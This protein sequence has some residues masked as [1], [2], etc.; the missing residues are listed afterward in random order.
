MRRT[1]R[2]LSVAALAGAVVGS[3]ASA[4]S[5][6]PAAEVS[7]GTVPPGG[8]V[9]VSVSCDSLGGSAPAALEATSEAFEEGTVQLKKVSGKDEKQAGAAYSG[10]ARVPPAENVEGDPDAA[11]PASA[12]TVDGTCPA[13]AGGEGKPWSATFTVAQDSGGG[14]GAAEGGAADGGAADGGGS[15]TEGGMGDGE[16]DGGGAEGGKG[17]VDG[18][19]KGGVDGGQGSSE[20][21]SRPCG[22]Q[23]SG[24]T[25]SHG[26]N[27]EPYADSTESYAD[28]A[29]PYTDKADP[30][31]DKS[32]PHSYETEH[33]AD[34]GGQHSEDCGGEAIHRGVEAGAG[35]AFT[36]SVPALAAGGLLIAGALGGAVYR[37]RRKTPSAED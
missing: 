13:A 14:K 32:E 11:G 22:E 33:H 27:A 17:G 35:G 26:D 15:G 1:V 12:W 2:A 34:T 18:G 6:D 3:T 24:N 8:S 31:L 37:L 5:A 20:G 21:G 4:A 29:A 9:T 19:G 16:G 25:E 36:D 23:H 10:T 30:S 7:P 28:K